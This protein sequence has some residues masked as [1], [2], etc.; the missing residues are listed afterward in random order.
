MKNRRFNQGLKNIAV[1]GYWED[2]AIYGMGT[3]REGDPL[4]ESIAGEC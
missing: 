1:W 3:N 2:A 4:F